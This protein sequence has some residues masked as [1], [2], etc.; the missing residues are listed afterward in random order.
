M[1]KI[2][3]GSALFVMFLIACGDDPTGP[4]GPFALT[5]TTTVRSAEIDFAD[6][7]PY[8]CEYKCVA[9]TEGGEKGEYADWLG[10]RLEWLVN[11]SVI[12]TFNLSAVELLNRF[13]D[14]TIGKDKKQN[15][16]RSASGT[17][18]YDLQLI[19]SARHSSGEILSDSSL[20]VC[21]FPPDV[22]GPANLAGTWTATW[23]K[24]QSPDAIVWQAELISSDG[25][26]SFDLQENGS[27]SGFTIY[28]SLAG[29]MENTG[30]SGTLT[31]Q[32]STSVTSASV[33]LTFAQGPYGTLV[34]TLT[35]VGNKL[36]LDVPEGAYFDFNRDGTPDIAGLEAR[37]TL[38]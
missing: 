36:Y 15:F 35:R 38:N 16:I 28:P 30:V 32:E 27:F 13:G 9:R 1:R 19:L 8:L 29:A 20:I 3:G 10:G 5:V 4:S 17:E 23:V 22:M 33:T 11:D 37:F 34:G 7:Q 2:I 12:H 14:G 24:W 6:D 18:D 26:L 25:A 31:V 21:D